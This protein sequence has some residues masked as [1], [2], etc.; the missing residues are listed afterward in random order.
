MIKYN[1]FNFIKIITCFIL[2]LLTFISYTLFVEYKSYKEQAEQLIE[3]QEEYRT[4][5]ADLRQQNLTQPDNNESIDSEKKKPFIV[6][7][8]KSDYLKKSSLNYLKTKNLKLNIK[9]LDNL[10]SSAISKSIQSNKRIRKNKGHNFNKLSRRQFLEYLEINRQEYNDIEI[11]WPLNKKEFWI[12]SRFGKRRFSNGKINFH[13]GVDLASPK[14]TT[15]KAVAD[16]IVKEA[17][18]STGKTGYGNNIILAH[19]NKYKTRYAH[20]NSIKVKVGETVVKGQK[21]GTVGNTG[22]VKGKNG[23][24]L[25]FEVHVNGKPINPLFVLP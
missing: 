8:R 11:I 2:I 7:N 23:F 22:H 15:I 13:Y 1:Y 24:H 12:V 25:H 21:I 17:Y 10:Y 19:N 18:Y 16:G 20:L 6:V 5:I 4:Y 14:G 3:L 9:K